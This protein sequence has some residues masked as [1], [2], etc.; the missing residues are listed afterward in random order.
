MAKQQNQSPAPISRDSQQAATQYMKECF[1]VQ[2][3]AYNFR[4][5]MQL[6]DRTYQRE[7]DYTA[8]QRRARLYN[9]AGDPTK[10]QN[11]TV[12]VVMP[13]VEAQVAELSEIFLTSYPLFPLFSKPQMQS[14]ALQM[15][16]AIGEQG[17][18]F[19]WAA[20]LQQCIR[21]SLKY[22]IMAAE[23]VWERKK[24]WSVVNDGLVEVS[25]GVAQDTLFAG[26]AVRR[27]DLYNVILDTR[28]EPFRVHED[29]EYAGYSKMMGRIKLKMF[30]SEL[31]P[32]RTMNIKEAF[33]S[34]TA[35]YTTGP[36]GEGF[37]VPQVN[38]NAFIDPGTVSGVGQSINWHAWGG[39]ENNRQIAYAGDV[40]EVSVL[41]ARIIPMEFKLTGVAARNTPQIWKFIYVNR[42]ICVFAEPQTNAHNWLPI[43]VA[44]ANEDGLGYQSKSFADN[45]APFQAIATA[46]YQ[47]GME[48]QRKKVYD[49]IL[50][51]PTFVN[52]ADIDNTS[53]VARIPVKQEAYGKPLSDAIY[54]IP[55]RDDQAHQIF[56]VADNVLRMADISNGTNRVQQGQFQKGN[57]TRG[58][59]QETMDKSN[60]RPRMTALVLENRFFTPLKQILKL[61]TLQ[62]QAPAELFNRNTK[63]PVK[64]DPVELRKAALEFRMADGLMPTDAYVN[65]EL[66]KAI[67]NIAST[68]PPILQQWD[69][70][71]MIMYWMKLEGATWIDDFQIVQ[72][73]ALPA[74]PPTGVIQ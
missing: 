10:L 42:S 73:A 66:F 23:V 7:L 71:G 54:P 1:R 53:P 38:S 56:A 15:E 59:F 27:I 21:D 13:Q 14:V 12:P 67:L 35:Q 20:E 44:Q 2:G 49:R 32:T 65:L 70:M 63:G 30:L 51:N 45:A 39:L 72:P 26:N 60:A 18:A 47:S 46:L 19:G 3:M 8:N 17:V 25:K 34:G 24:V 41:Y 28:V 55:Y 69:I 57:K 4:S 9:E 64:V 58:E 37:F 48:S 62:Y 52:K 61:N 50:Y 29:G 33:E 5:R 6:I 22:N 74:A 36:A 43:I 68:F 31:D 40:Y 16:T 11:L